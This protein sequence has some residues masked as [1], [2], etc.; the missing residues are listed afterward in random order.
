MLLFIRKLLN[1]LKEKK[2]TGDMSRH[3]VHALKYE[4]MCF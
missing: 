2:Y 4:D 3:R 1:G